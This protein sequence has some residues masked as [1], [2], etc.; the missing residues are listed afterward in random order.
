MSEKLIPDDD[1]AEGIHRSEKFEGSALPSDYLTLNIGPSHPATHGAL[2]I[3]AMIDGETIVEA[4]SEIGY[5]H[6][7]FEKEAED[8][9]WS[10]VMPYTDRL[11]Y[12]SAMLNNCIYADA[13]EK[14]IGVEI[15]SAPAWCASS[16]A[17][18]RG[19]STT[20]CASA[21][22]SWTSAR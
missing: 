15:R 8:H 22:T 20:W 16:S 7:C 4:K 21:P 9:T 14:M 13:V 10:Q 2:R 3:E 18:F 19:S 5:L 17:N 11:N 6:R 1:L 12:V